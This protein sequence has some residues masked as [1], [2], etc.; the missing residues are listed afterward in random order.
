MNLYSS[1]NFPLQ[2]Y[3]VLDPLELSYANII[4]FQKFGMDSG[5]DV[6]EAITEE[7]IGVFMCVRVC[8]KC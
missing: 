6:S 7:V 3:F 5:P 2:I 8:F 1:A 4:Y